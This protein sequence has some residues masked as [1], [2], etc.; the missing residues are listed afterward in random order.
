MAHLRHTCR[1][2]NNRSTSLTRICRLASW[3]GFTRRGYNVLN[4][5]S[6]VYCTFLS[7]CL[8][9]D[10]T[11]SKH[12]CCSDSTAVSWYSQVPRHGSNLVLAE[13]TNSCDVALNTSPTFIDKF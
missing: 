7:L 13:P 8:S 1:S 9:E 3:Y 11:S 5:V 10:S 4:L 2:L 12:S 6:S